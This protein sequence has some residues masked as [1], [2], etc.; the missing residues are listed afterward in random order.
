MKRLLGG[1]AL[2]CILTSSGRAFGS[3]LLTNPVVMVTPIV[4]DF[5]STKTG[6][7][8][9][10]TFLVQNAAGGKLVGK[11]S[12]PAPFKII[13]GGNYSLKENAAQVVTIIYTPTH[14]SVDT[15]TVTFSGARGA[16][17]TVTGRG[18]GDASGRK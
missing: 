13:S 8:L 3:N 5:G 1:L 10:N 14:A 6:G 18:I 9:T 16:K 15:Q 7:S 2:V 17:A 4:L 11:A 12:V